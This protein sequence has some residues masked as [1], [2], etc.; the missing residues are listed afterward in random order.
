M[1]YNSKNDEITQISKVTEP[2]GVEKNTVYTDNELEVNS[3]D[4]LVMY[5]DGVVESVNLAGRQYSKNRLIQIVTENKNLSS[6]EIASLVKTDIKQFCGSVR[7]HDDQTV[8]II[9]IQ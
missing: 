4:I 7:Q 3:G 5:S 8:L 9:K 2:I 6:K 1:Y